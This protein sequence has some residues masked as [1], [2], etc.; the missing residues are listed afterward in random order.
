MKINHQQNE[1]VS[2]HQEIEDI[3]SVSEALMFDNVFSTLPLERRTEAVSQAAVLAD[4]LNLE[5]VPKNILSD[6]FIL[7]VLQ[8]DGMLISS[9]DEERRT[10]EMYHAALENSGLALCY[11]PHEMI[12]PEI[13]LSAVEKTGAALEHVPEE[14]KTPE[15]CRIA[16]NNCSKSNCLDFE[17]IN[18]IPFPEV[19]LEHLKKY[20]TEK[21]DPFMVFGSIDKNVITSEMAEL[22]VRLEPSCIQFV[23]D[24]LKTSEMCAK[25]VE[26]DWMNMRFIPEKMKNKS[27]CEIAISRS[28]HAQQLV[29]ERFKS[30]EMY[31]NAVK[32][33]GD[34]LEYV[35]EK[36]MT[37]E[38][39]LQAIKSNPEAKEFVPKHFGGPYNIYE[40]YGKL[41]E[42]MFLAGQLSFE[43]VQKAFTGE[44]VL[45]SGIKF[46]KNVTLDDFILHYDLKTSQ[47]NL[48]RVEEKQSQKPVIENIKRPEKRRRMK[49]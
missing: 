42:A 28:I 24:H 33:N 45:L 43:Q 8:N 12:T 48:K 29:P 7:S 13:A 37:P 31:M 17:I 34:N 47:I 32:R 44:P 18:E 14:L 25:S 4:G 1:H 19:C 46:A 27:L 38:V 49:M 30:P 20:E 9:L 35:P 36:F 23:P 16:L 41:K 5:Y 15:M 39:C 10:P 6:E 2:T 26:R 21:A 22:A 3:K 11:V 40:F